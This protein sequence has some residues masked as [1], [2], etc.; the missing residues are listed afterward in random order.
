MKSITDFIENFLSKERLKHVGGFMATTSKLVILVGGIVTVF[1]IMNQNEMRSD[2]ESSNL[3]NDMKP[4]SHLS[5]ENSYEQVN[6]K[7]PDYRF[8]IE[9]C[10]F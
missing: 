7:G 8:A 6:E 10:E 5:H 9:I 2:P 3:H 4:L 1:F